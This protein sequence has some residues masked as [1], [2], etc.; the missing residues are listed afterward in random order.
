MQLKKVTS[1]DIQTFRGAL[2]IKVNESDEQQ[3]A[4]SY[5]F[6]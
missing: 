2:C 4:M 5:G 1:R 3:D 6:L